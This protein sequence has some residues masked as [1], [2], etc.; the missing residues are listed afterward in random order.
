M[1][2]ARRIPR[3]CLGGLALMLL[4]GV[5]QA[6][7]PEPEDQ[8]EGEGEMAAEHAEDTGDAEV[9][10]GYEG[11]TGPEMWRLDAFAVCDTGVE[12]SPVDLTAATRR[13]GRRRPDIRVAGYGGGGR[14]NGHTIQVT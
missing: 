9:H 5:Q 6:C 4:V 1:Q 3:T 2:A 10:W 14:D 12:Q 11:D 7:Q 8:T 13:R